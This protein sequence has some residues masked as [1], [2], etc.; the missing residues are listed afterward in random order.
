MN[1]GIFGFP[2]GG[3]RV[4]YI[5]NLQQT[6]IEFPLPFRE[7]QVIDFDFAFR[8]GAG[9]IANE[10]QFTFNTDF[11]ITNYSN[12]L[13]QVSNASV[14]GIAVASN[15]FGAI[16]PGQLSFGFGKFFNQF[17]RIVWMSSCFRVNLSGT[18]VQETIFG[19][20]SNALLSAVPRQ[21]PVHQGRVITV[22]AQAFAPGSRFTLILPE[23]MQ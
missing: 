2:V 17:G 7:G 21:L 8:E 19:V 9:G 13:L 22:G 3:R 11:V 5:A 6:E 4:D 20:W 15:R 1:P 18:I 16:D 12:I 14:Q 10:L 23:G